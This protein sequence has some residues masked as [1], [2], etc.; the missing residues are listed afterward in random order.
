MN[1]MF[2]IY[3]I[4]VE[5]KTNNTRYKKIN[6]DI[7][8]GLLRYNMFWSNFEPNPSSIKCAD[9]YRLIPNNNEKDRIECVYNHYHCY[10]TSAIDMFNYI[11]NKEDNVNTINNCVNAGILFMDH[12]NG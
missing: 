5:F 6:A 7:N 10:S 1:H 12:Q 11:Y 4:Q 9:G 3:I 8:P 2:I